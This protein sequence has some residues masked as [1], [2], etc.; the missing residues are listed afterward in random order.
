M[1]PFG[2]RLLRQA[3]PE[4]LLDAQHV[5]GPRE[6]KAT[7]HP[8]DMGVDGEGRHTEGLRQDDI[9]GFPAHSREGLEGFAG[10]RHLTPVTRYQH[11]GHRHE[12]P[13]LGGPKATRADEGSY[14]GHVR[15]G[16]RAGIGKSSE[17]TGRH[18]V[19]TDI[20]ALC[21]KNHG[22]EQFKRIAEGQFRPRIRVGIGQGLPDSRD[23]LPF[24]GTWTPALHDCSPIASQSARK[25]ARAARNLT[26]GRS[27]P[28][29][30]C[31]QLPQSP[32]GPS[33]AR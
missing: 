18:Q 28:G 33:R 29:K 7:G 11:A 30:R 26:D 32:S 17:Q 23:T 22:T 9:G 16:K 21:R 31:V 15:R 14:L 13:G 1:V 8:E 2:P 6:A 10:I 25:A 12:V 4:V 19:H 5:S 20:R 27:T 24:V 3:D